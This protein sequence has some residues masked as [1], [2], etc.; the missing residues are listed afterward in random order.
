MTEHAPAWTPEAPAAPMAP[1][2]PPTPPAPQMPA[3]FAMPTDAASMLDMTA[4]L[5]LHPVAPAQP[6]A[7]AQPAAP[8]MPVAPEQAAPAAHPVVQVIPSAPSFAAGAHQAATPQYQPAHVDHPTSLAMPVQ[9]IGETTPGPLPD[10]FAGASAVAELGGVATASPQ[11]IAD[12]RAATMPA[13]EPDAANVEAGGT[14]W[15]PGFALVAAMFALSWQ[16]VAYYARE[17]LPTRIEAG[18]TLDNFDVIISRIPLLDG[19]AGMA[20]GMLLAAVSIVLLL[21]GVRK[22]VREP[23]LQGAVGVLGL[24]ALVA[25]VLVPRIAG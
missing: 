7:F 22:G 4:P 18:V 12:L 13:T 2:A 25:T 23:V 5:V 17:V 20:A 24:V 8:A 6:A 21:A 11:D 19:T 3:G 16:L 9:V 14:W 10:G 1:P 15:S